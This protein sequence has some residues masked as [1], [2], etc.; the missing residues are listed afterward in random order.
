MILPSPPTQTLSEHNVERYARQ[1]IIP[2]VG[3]EGQ[4]ILCAAEVFIDGHPVGRRVASQYLRA[5]GVH[6]VL[7]TNPPPRVDCV[8]LTGTADLP[9]ARV[10]ALARSA[11]LLT[12][13]AVLS[14][15]I[16]G[17]VAEA[18]QA[19]SRPSGSLGEPRPD[20]LDVL[21]YLAG[22]DVATTTVAALLGWIKAGEYYELSLA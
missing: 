5:A 16:C 9:E 18:G 22:A 20:H 11:P 14:G 12:W 3:A 1:I 2:G 6:V 13:Y 8:V 7:A 15:G 17:G 19:I 4:Q 10:E 21:H